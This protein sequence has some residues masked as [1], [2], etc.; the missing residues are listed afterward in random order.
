MVQTE[1]Q[2]LA[3]QRPGDITAIAFA[4]NL[5]TSAAN[6]PELGGAIE[7]IVRD[8]LL[9]K[10]PKASVWVIDHDP[11]I[12]QR[13][14]AVRVLLQIASDPSL[15]T[16]RPLVSADGL[17]FKSS[18]HLFS[19]T[20][21]GLRAF[22]EPLFSSRAPW[23]W[24]FSAGCPG[25]VI[26]YSLGELV[27]GRS[28]EPAEPLQLLSP[29]GRLGIAP[30]P[31]PPPE[32]FDAAFR[33]WVEHLDLLFTEMTDPCRHVEADG[34]YNVLGHFETLLSVEQA[35]RHVQSLSVHD[36][37]A[38]AQRS[39]MFQALDVIAALRSPGFDDLCKL[40]VAKEAL[41]E[42]EAAIDPAAHDVL[43]LR[44]RNAVK[45]LDDLN[46]GFFL[47]SRITGPGLRMPGKNGEAIEPYE[48]AA[49]M[50]LRVLRN[51]VHG[52]GGR[53][54]LAEE[55]ARVLLASHDGVIPSDLPDLAY[56]YLLRLLAL[57]TELR[58]SHP[59]ANGP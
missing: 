57:P 12:S 5:I 30:V 22:L 31:Q 34:S 47:P 50:L 37:D 15:L 45:A 6:P 32:A 20:S 27:L 7:Q 28:P 29:N 2:R 19:D 24:G 42:V 59:G 23:V 51:S 46:S 40:S 13:T 3:T 52:F 1:L 11:A 21:L 25:A 41:E 4:L 17:A 10:A 55:R 33:W 43:L 14:T 35:F 26:A 38:H 58:G 36:R 53:K 54:G 48:D 9:L 16:R 8:E 44:A 39:L 18:R 56:L 49:A